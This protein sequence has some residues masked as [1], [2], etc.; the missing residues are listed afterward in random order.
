MYSGVSS[1]D[2]IF[3]KSSGTPSQFSW[4]FVTE[5]D[6]IGIRNYTPQ[7]KGYIVAGYSRPRAVSPASN[8]AKLG[9][10]IRAAQKIPVAYPSQSS[11]ADIIIRGWY[12]KSNELFKAADKSGL[13]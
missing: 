4:F 6:R 3:Q 9:F 10:G 12:K 1:R 11:L 5:L 7:L 2:A 8:P 13:H